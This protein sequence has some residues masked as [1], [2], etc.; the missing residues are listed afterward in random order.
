MLVHDDLAK[1]FSDV[2]D[3]VNLSYFVGKMSPNKHTR[4][5]QPMYTS[6]TERSQEASERSGF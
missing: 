6:L 5:R 1:E 4:Q 3:D 2:L